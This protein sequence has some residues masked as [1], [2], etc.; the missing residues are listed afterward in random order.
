MFMCNMRTK[1]RNIVQIN[2]KARLFNVFLGLQKESAPVIEAVEPFF[3]ILLKAFPRFF[4]TLFTVQ[5]G[6]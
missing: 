3:S 1:V 2:I 4:H 6:F 5:M